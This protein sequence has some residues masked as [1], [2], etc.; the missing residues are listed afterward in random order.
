MTELYRIKKEYL[1]MVARYAMETKLDIHK[2]YDKQT[3]IKNGFREEIL[4]K[5]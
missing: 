3:W 2:A 1:W 4:E 5:I